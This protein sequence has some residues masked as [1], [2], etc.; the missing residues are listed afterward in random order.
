MQ[1]FG[2]TLIIICLILSFCT[3]FNIFLLGTNEHFYFSA[4]LYYKIFMPRIWK[5]YKNA[6]KYGVKKY[7]R[8]SDIERDR[9]TGKLPLYYLYP[10]AQEGGEIKYILYKK[11]KWITSNFQLTS[12]I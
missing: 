1:I 8:A 5:E 4:V 11:N 7:L 3:F 6:K 2:I 10:I 12:I 9:D